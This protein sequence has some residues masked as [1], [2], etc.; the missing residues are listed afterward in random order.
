[1]T[2]LD[3]AGSLLA[4]GTRCD[5]VACLGSPLSTRGSVKMWRVDGEGLE[6]EKGGVPGL[7]VQH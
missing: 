2:H 6:E 5:V 1:M 4:L 7:E 3:S